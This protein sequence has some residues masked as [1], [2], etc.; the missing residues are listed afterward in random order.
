FWV[1]R[2][3]QNKWWALAVSVALP[4]H[5][6]YGAWLGLYEPEL[7]AEGLVLVVLALVLEGWR[8]T[9]KPQFAP[10]SWLGLSLGVL[11][12]IGLAWPLLPPAGL[13]ATLLVLIGLPL[14][15]GLAS[16]YRGQLSQAPSAWNRAAALV[17]GLLAPLGGLLLA[18][19]AVER[20][21][22]PGSTDTGVDLLRA[23]L[24]PG[25]EGPG[26]SGFT[27]AE[28]EIWCWPLPPWLVLVLMAWGLWRSLRRGWRQTARGRPPLSWGM[29]LYAALASVRIGLH[30]PAARV[31][32]LLP[33]TLLALLLTV[34]CVA[35]VV[36]GIGDQLVLAP[37]QERDE[38]AN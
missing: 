35:D 9:Y 13:E 23:A 36:R 2:C 31:T 20:F 6:W 26:F 24:E 11:I 19:V 32:V 18:P 33:L 38:Q 17:L 1:L 37:P 29:A 3:C 12:C 21:D 10:W 22:W 28:L 5:P 14:G 15:A 27:A 7:R 16:R 25:L 8:L 30:P 4:F 34:F